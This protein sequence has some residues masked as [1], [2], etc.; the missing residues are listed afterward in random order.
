[1]CVAL[2]YGAKAVELAKGKSAV[3]VSSSEEVISVLE[4]FQRA[5]TAGELDTQLEAT[6]GALREGFKK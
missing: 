2:R 3:E 4:V 1:M 6:S 5:V